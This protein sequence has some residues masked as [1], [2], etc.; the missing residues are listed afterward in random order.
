MSKPIVSARGRADNTHCKALPTDGTLDGLVSRRIEIAI[1]T[2]FV[3]T[4]T[5]SIQTACRFQAD[6][7]AVKVYRDHSVPALPRGFDIT[8][9]VPPDIQTYGRFFNRLVLRPA[10][11]TTPQLSPARYLIDLL[12]LKGV[13]VLS[14]REGGEAL[15]GFCQAH[16]PANGEWDVRVKAWRIPKLEIVLVGHFLAADFNRMFG[17]EFLRGLLGTGGVKFSGHEPLGLVESHGAFGAAPIVEFIRTRA[18]ELFAVALKTEDTMLPF[19][20]TRARDW[21]YVTFP[22][23]QAFAGRGQGEGYAYAQLSRFISADVKKQFLC[24]SAL[25]GAHENGCGHGT[26]TGSQKIRRQIESMW[27]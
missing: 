7:V 3:D 10:G 9:Y 25:S 16:G 20:V 6:T 21:L 17:N 26:P 22:L 14:R 11:P 27:S 1:D 13:E 12:G 4:L 2:E 15:A 19:A 24:R 8:Q 18:G 23:T 5:L